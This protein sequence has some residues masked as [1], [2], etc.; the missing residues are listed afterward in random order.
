MDE[1]DL[2]EESGLVVRMAPVGDDEHRSR[3]FHLDAPT[4]LRVTGL[5]EGVEGRLY[6][7]GWIVEAAGGRT[8]WEMAWANTVHGGGAHKNRLFQGE[9][10]LPAG[11]YVA[12]YVSDGSHSF[13]GFNDD[14]PRRPLAWGLTVRRAER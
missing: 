5:G 13:A 7:R 2:A 10:T 14:P 8:V 9:I 3:R 12:H 6:D 1:A 11:D 4:R